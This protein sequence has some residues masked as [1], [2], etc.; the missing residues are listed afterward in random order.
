MRKSGRKAWNAEDHDLAVTTLHR[1]WWDN[2]N[3]EIRD[4]MYPNGKP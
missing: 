2:I 1:L 4:A 3:P